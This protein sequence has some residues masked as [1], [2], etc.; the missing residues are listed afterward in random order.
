V[1]Y[2]FHIL[3]KIFIYLLALVNGTIQDTLE[4]LRKTREQLQRKQ[5]ELAVKNSKLVDVE[6]GVTLLNIRKSIYQSQK[7][8]ML[9][10]QEEMVEKNVR[11]FKFYYTNIQ[12][13]VQNVM[14]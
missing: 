2:R 11:P 8:E 4:N 6:L 13:Q 9:E 1:N 7:Q 5:G 14:H 10:A 12:L 3:F